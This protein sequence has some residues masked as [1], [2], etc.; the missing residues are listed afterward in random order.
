MPKF[1]QDHVIILPHAQEYVRLYDIGSADILQTLNEPEVQEG[2]A[3]GRYTVEKNI[4][5]RRIYVYYYRTLPLQSKNNS[6]YAIV[7]FVGFT[8]LPV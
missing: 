7:D 2:L 3:Q 8:A 5:D 6:T 1:T 4:G